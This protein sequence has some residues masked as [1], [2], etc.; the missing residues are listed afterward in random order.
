M[1]NNRIKLSQYRE[2]LDHLT[3]YG[4]PK[5]A[6]DATGIPRDTVAPDHPLIRK[7]VASWAARL[8]DGLLGNDGDSNDGGQIRKRKDGT[9]YKVASTRTRASG[10]NIR[11]LLERHLPELYPRTEVVT[12]D[13]A[14][15]AGHAWLSGAMAAQRTA[16]A[17]AATVDAIDTTA[18]VDA[19]D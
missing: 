17:I 2:Y 19:S 16:P 12:M 1:I 13:A 11:W 9:E 6:A 3:R 14:A 10:D 8:V 15:A 4:S 7:Q 18:T 5:L